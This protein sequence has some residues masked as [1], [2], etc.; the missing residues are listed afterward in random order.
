MTRSPRIIAT[1]LTLLAL[2]PAIG[3]AMAQNESAE[4][5]RIQIMSGRDGLY[6]TYTMIV[7]IN[8]DPDTV[9][10]IVG[11]WGLTKMRSAFMAPAIVE[12]SGNGATRRLEIDKKIGGGYIEELQHS[13]DDVKRTY[14]YTMLES[15][16]LPWVD[17]RGTTTVTG[18]AN[19]QSLIF[20]DVR[21]IPYGQS[22]A[23]ALALSIANNRPWMQGLVA[24]FDKPRSNG[25]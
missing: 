17:Y 13:R 20:Y 10:D 21:F 9:W 15:G 5:G 16:P 22:H 14:S 18:Y 3:P 6:A 24:R 19:G 11:D 7:R 2:A 23:E 8:A 1:L 12:G 25:K 4:D